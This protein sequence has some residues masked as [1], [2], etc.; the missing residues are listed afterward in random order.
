[1]KKKLLTAVTLLMILL[2]AAL[3]FVACEKYEKD[4]TEEDEITPPTYTHTVKNGTFYNSATTSTATSGNTAILDDVKNWT[5]TSASVTSSKKG[6]A[7]VLVAAI[8]LA[9]E[10]AFNDLANAILR[11]SEDA[12]GH[13]LS[14]PFSPKNPGVNDKTP[15]VNKLDKDGKVITGEDGNAEKEREDTYAAVVASTKTAGSVYLA[16]ESFSLE[17]DSVYLFQFSVASTVDTSDASKQPGAWVNLTGDM[18]YNFKCINT[19]GDWKTYYL[20]IQTNKYSSMSVKANLWLGYG[21]KV[22][23]AAVKDNSVYATRGVAFFDNVLCEKVD[24]DALTAQIKDEGLATYGAY[25]Y[26]ENR[27]EDDDF[28]AFKTAIVSTDDGVN[29]YV[30]A[31]SYYALVNAD[32]E[33]RNKL[34]S[35]GDSSTYVKY[36]YTFRENNGS[37][38]LSKYALSSSGS[39]DAKYYGS[40]DLSKLYDVTDDA[41]HKDNYTVST[42]YGGIG[43]SVGFY[44]MSYEDWKNKVMNDENHN[45]SAADESFA[46]M[47]YNKELMANKITS[48]DKIMIE[49]DRY[50]AISVWVLVWAKTYEDGANLNYYPAYSGSDATE[51]SFTNTEKQLYALLDYTQE[52]DAKTAKI[53]AMQNV[54]VSNYSVTT[55]EYDAAVATPGNLAKDGAASGTYRT[56]AA[57]WLKDLLDNAPEE[58]R[59]TATE[60]NDLSGAADLFYYTYLH[61]QVNLDAIDGIN[62]E[63]KAAIETLYKAECETNLKSFESMKTKKD[64]YDKDHNDYLTAKADYEKRYKEWTELNGTDTD[65]PVKATVKLTGAGDIPEQTVAVPKGANTSSWTKVTFYVQGNQLSSRQ[66]ALEMAMGTGTDYSTYMIGGAFFDNVEVKQYKNKT[67]VP[68]ADEDIIKLS[69]MDSVQDLQFGGLVG[70]TETLTAEAAQAI[71]DNNWEAVKTSGTAAADAEKVSVSV[72][73]EN[74]FGKI[75]VS[76]VDQYLYVLSY[77][78]QVATASTLQYVG[79]DAIK[80]NPNSFYRF[81]FSVKTENVDKE[82]GISIKLLYGKDPANIT[83]VKDSTITKY[84]N[85]GDWAEVVYYICGDLLDAYY[86]AIEV[87]MGSGTRFITDDY[88]SGKVMLAAFNCL[89]IDYDEYNNHATGDKIVSGVSLYNI[90]KDIE[91]ASYMFTNPYYAKLDYSST[92]KEAFDENGNLTGIAATSNWTKETS[93]SFSNSYDK[94]ANITLD[95]NTKKLTWDAS[96]GVS[97]NAEVKPA[98][99]YEIWAKYTDDEEKAKE[100]LFAKVDKDTTEYVIPGDWDNVRPTYF[101]VKAIGADGISSIGTYTNNTLGAAGKTDLPQA[102]TTDKEAKAEAGTV[103]ATEGGFGTEVGVDYITPYDTI[104][105]LTSSYSTV[106]TV[107]SASISSGLASD[108]YF[109]I[110]VWAKTDVGTY[111]SITLGGTS[112]SLQAT[113]D[114]SQLGFVMITTNGNWE[115]YS[116]Y[117]KTGN[118]N[119][120]MYIRY[121]LGNPYAVKKTMTNADSK[122]Y[123]LSE[124]LSKGNAYFDA[125]RVT[126]VKESEFNAAKGK[127]ENKGTDAYANVKEITHANFYKNTANY[128]YIMEYVIDS[129]DAYTEVSAASTDNDM[130]GNTPSN[131]NRSYDSDLGT[132]KTLASYG[133]YNRNSE[134]EDMKTAIK[135]LYSYT[136]GTGTDK[137]V[138]YPFSKYIKNLYGDKLDCTDWEDAEWNDFMQ[139]FLSVNRKDT[140]GNVIY[141]GRDNVL[142]MSNKSE[143]GYAQNYTIGSSYQYTAKKGTYTKITFSARTLIA[144][145]VEDVTKDTNGDTQKKYSYTIDNAFGEFRV[146]PNTSEADKTLSVKINSAVYGNDENN[147]YEDVTYTVYL[148]NPTETDN[149][150]SWAFFL[151]DEEKD[152]DET[153][154]PNYFDDYI[155]GMMA[156]DLISAETVTAEE[157]QAA[158]TAAS[159]ANATTYTYEYKEKETDTSDTDNTDTDNTDKEEEKESFWDKIVKNEYFWLYISSFIIA[160]VIVIAVIVILVRKFKKKHPK[161][162]EVENNVKTKKDD[163]KEPVVEKQPDVKEEPLEADEYTEEIKPR[164]VQRTVQGKTRKDRKKK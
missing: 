52:G 33:L 131:Y 54:V 112:G 134:S 73:K 31:K 35:Y 141:D 50:Y 39:L 19:N 80:I 145:V 96:T 158:T 9:N 132:E 95:T 3:A 87:D 124:D 67:D 138:V 105:K 15:M 153:T 157:Y 5:A 69:K 78:N 36:F 12:E 44:A 74:N 152:D 11:V 77:E 8:D 10:T 28:N 99:G 47:I 45:V 119:A 125:V 100:I 60:R 162:V 156:I 93:S 94:P 71:V 98:G 90:K 129:F 83:D 43:S 101:S 7:G 150:V 111:A 89:K 122:T 102:Q 155:V 151:G 46:L 53:A 137:T 144:R 13:A 59:L 148:Y 118:F 115:E 6:D 135:Q 26:D 113:T 106:L 41:E 64:K 79:D 1:M 107:K 142:V 61:T 65:S 24:K 21:P 117:V 55:T 140:Q 40:V 57:A 139:T 130:I 128:A 154:T 88:V 114:A 2:V 110:S 161:E 68:A 127:D 147:V 164:Y 66:L 22:H 91:S 51:P 34:S 104:L 160:L 133:V 20:F 146:T 86:I 37:N 108:G 58:S 62:A 27:Y 38:N 17:K 56:D 97:G 143:K 109:K 48:S 32:M 136:S 85:E 92:D 126:A 163:V 123:Y 49:A 72:V 82:K 81:A 70:T 29:N 63:K 42:S 103:L 84:T 30:N 25:A 116:F 120:K 14:S 149:T 23:T 18:E 76:N 121:S 4:T 159:A 75:S 16:S